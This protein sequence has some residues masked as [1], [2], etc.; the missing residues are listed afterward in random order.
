[1]RDHEDN[2]KGIVGILENGARK[3]IHKRVKEEPTT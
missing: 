2:D 3:L 1:L